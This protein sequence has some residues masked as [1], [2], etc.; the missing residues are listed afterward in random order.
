MLKSIENSFKLSDKE[1]INII[2]N[3][4]FEMDSGLRGQISSLKMIPA[5]VDRPTGKEK[6]RFIAL[7]LGGT[8]LRVL[9]FSL[10]GQGKASKIK[11]NKFLLPQ[12][13]IKG[14]SSQLFG[15]IASKIK[16]FSSTDFQKYL[17]F[18]FSFPVKQTSINSGVLLH[19]N[20]D[21]SV[22]GVKGK[23]V[24]DLLK[25]SL[26]KEKINNIKVSALANDTVGTLVA[27]AYADHNCDVGVIWGTGTNA[28]YRE[29]L[30]KITKYKTGK[31]SGH[32]VVNIEWGNFNKLKATIFD[33]ILDETSLNPGSQMLEKMV[34]GMYLGELARL[35]LLDLMKEGI[36]FKREQKLFKKAASFKTEYMSLIEADKTSDLSATKK[37]LIKLGVK[38]S[39]LEDRLFV[40]KI[41]KIV[42]LRA[43]RISAAVLT[44]VIQKIDPG[45]NRRHSVA[46]DGTL[47]EKHPSFA[48][49]VNIT[50][51]S[52][53]NR[54]ADNV[55][56]LLTKD[57]S[58]AGAAIISAIGE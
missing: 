40:Q 33:V 17:G 47:F 5:F 3:F 36:L 58:G 6:G 48:K 55:K 1:L 46:V 7:D 52:I 30:Q 45:V 15:F 24:V 50:I 16:E 27:R 44:A 31:K 4:R 53:L 14:N 12:D 21:F 35:V 43:A 10:N 2:K 20:K 51:K 34:S 49:N 8:N 26:K 41:C 11:E 19:W 54:K 37:L 18:T 28:C 13:C 29:N 22:K 56:L 39:R 25:K 9:E 42:S 38:N 32:M 57:G 23:D